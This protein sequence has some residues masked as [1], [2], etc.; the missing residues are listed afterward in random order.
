MQNIAKVVFV[1]AAVLSA[2]SFITVRAGASPQ[3]V[4]DD[5]LDG[6][7]LPPTP[8][9]AGRVAPTEVPMA[10]PLDIEVT[11]DW[12]QIIAE[13]W[14][15]VSTGRMP[16]L[17][18][19]MI[20]GEN[21]K[22]DET[23]PL[24]AEASAEE[25][26]SR[27]AKA[28]IAA[29]NSK[30]QALQKD[31]DALLDKDTRCKDLWKL[32]EKHIDE[33]HNSTVV[34]FGA[35][36]ALYVPARKEHRSMKTSRP[37][38][39][40]RGQ[41]DTS[42]TVRGCISLR[43]AQ[44]RRYATVIYSGHKHYVGSTAEEAD[45][46]AAEA[47]GERVLDGNTYDTEDNTHANTLRRADRIVNIRNK[48]KSRPINHVAGNA[49]V[50][51]STISE[52]VEKTPE[53]YTYAV[54][55]ELRSL[56][57]NMLPHE[58]EQFLGQLLGLSITTFIPVPLP[59]DHY[60]SYWK[61]AE[62]LALAAAHS[63]GLTI[64]AKTIKDNN[65]YNSWL[66]S[67]ST[68]TSKRNE[69]KLDGVLKVQLT[70]W[71]NVKPT[72][73]EKGDKKD[74]KN[75]KSLPKKDDDANKTKKKDSDTK[76]TPPK[77]RRLQSW[78]SNMGN[79]PFHPTPPKKDEKKTGEG[80]ASKSTRKLMPMNLTL[81]DSGVSLQ[82]LN[83]LSITTQD[84]SQI[85]L[86]LL[87]SADASTMVANKPSDILFVRGALE[88]KIGARGR[89]NVRLGIDSATRMDHPR[90]KKAE[91]TSEHVLGE[92]DD[93]D[94]APDDVSEDDDQR[95][96]DDDGDDIV[97]EASE[98]P[99][100]SVAKPALTKAQP[101]PVPLNK[102]LKN[103]P[104]HE[105]LKM[106]S[107]KFSPFKEVTYGLAKTN[108][109]ELY[110]QD[111][112]SKAK[113]VKIDDSSS[114]PEHEK[115][116]APSTETKPSVV[117]AKSKQ[118]KKK[119][120]LSKTKNAEENTGNKHSSK[121]V[122]FVDDG[123]GKQKKQ[124]AKVKPSFRKPKKV[125]V[126]TGRRRRGLRRRLL[127]A[128]DVKRYIRR[129]FL[130][131]RDTQWANDKI[132][133][134]LSMIQHE[135]RGFE[136]WWP[137]FETD[138]ISHRD[139]PDKAKWS[140]LINGE[141][142]GLLSTKLALAFP[143]STVVSVKDDTN[144]MVSHLELLELLGINNNVLCNGR[145]RMATEKK[146]AEGATARYGILGMDAFQIFF[147]HADRLDEFESL[148]GSLLN[149]AS[150]TFM[151]LPDWDALTAAVDAMAN[152][153]INQIEGEKA[154]SEILTA[155][156]LE[157]ASKRGSADPWV[158]LL[159]AAA[160]RADLQGVTMRMLPEMK[161]N[162]SPS[163]SIRSTLLK[164]LRRKIP[165]SSDSIAQMFP[166]KEVP[167]PRIRIVRIDTAPWAKKM[168]AEDT[169]ENGGVS[170]FALRRLGLIPKQTAKI[171]RLFMRL[172]FNKIESEE[173]GS[174]IIAPWNTYYH[175]S[176]GGYRKGFP[177]IVVTFA[178]TGNSYEAYDVPE[179]EEAEEDAEKLV[180]P[181][182][183]TLAKELTEEDVGPKGEFS[184]LELNSGSGL[185]SLAVAEKFPGATVLSVE[186]EAA[187]V[188]AHLQRIKKLGQSRVN[189]AG[190]D[191]VQD[192]RDNVLKDDLAK[193]AANNWVCNT[194][195]GLGL[196]K[197]L[198]ES[199]E[200]IR[201]QVF[202]GDLVLDHMV[203]SGGPEQM[204]EA[205][206]FFMSSGMTTFVTLPSAKSL[207]LGLYMFY[208]GS[209]ERSDTAST[210]FALTSHPRP[211]YMQAEM[212]ILSSMASVPGETK[213]S[214]KLLPGEV[215]MARVD[216]VNM[217]RHVNHHFDYAKDGHQR[218]Y[219]MHVG[220]NASLTAKHGRQKQSSSRAISP[221]P[222]GS[223]MNRG[224]VVDVYITRQHDKWHIPYGTL[225]GVTLI[226]VLRMGL[227]ET[228]REAAYHRFVNLPLY[229]DMAPWNI[230][231]QGARMAYIDYDTKDVT[232]DSV[233]PLTYR[234]LSV[235]FNYKRTVED[236]KR[237]GP[238]SHNDYGFPHINSC[239]GSEK[240]KKDFLRLSGG[241][242]KCKESNAPVPCGD[243]SCQSDYIS[244]L[245]VLSKLEHT[246]RKK[247]HRRSTEAFLNM[248][249][250]KEWTF[251]GSGMSV[252]TG[253]GVE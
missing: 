245:K 95:D 10:D 125:T 146:H 81:S 222:E 13:V 50:T 80:T 14:A 22:D 217:T 174:A 232:Y 166:E 19:P 241:N 24:E 226:T 168:S 230:V 136:R 101:A 8:V 100:I 33:K 18:D 248:W 36:S 53:L 160:Q 211:R 203:D 45:F 121:P 56:T 3:N 25:E 112:S 20:L 114:L 87:R 27:R 57:Q 133:G 62:E 75:D 156:Y 83:L 99:G 110:K 190:S 59:D 223:H 167:R 253:A 252:N 102:G 7:A 89:K 71:V 205:L 148:V 249:R 64:D 104:H 109:K 162:V 26:N 69:Q 118:N 93:N 185:L 143:Q 97:E 238:S 161:P 137:L 237:C 188:A 11:K 144:D 44:A 220:R 78:Y 134:Q 184:F 169:D 55:T 98:P 106:M 4:V 86:T 191:P 15:A 67:Y 91:D 130:Q 105:L 239:V 60:F 152:L 212:Q 210:T 153:K 180:D 157:A 201:W 251:R 31:G 131:K 85:F 28:F 151:E 128:Q 48:L 204:K 39:A 179:N 42:L 243:G 247:P 141:H 30:N 172:D 135:E 61:N 51:P 192:A 32:L 193:V 37:H 227:V 233:V 240:N 208:H 17:P 72:K 126:D 103:V 16:K 213:L 198:Y 111:E 195:V 35:G 58:F 1:V 5:L 242:H 178:K 164:R 214:M 140:I 219:D 2:T 127:S 77:R 197:H 47:A 23:N 182:W 234:V 235:L 68:S 170:V 9:S 163:R 84:S 21:N 120:K 34:E 159:S 194:P 171:F 142:L 147:K 196:L 224:V 186:S 221:L 129:P 70:N 79:N 215:H 66:P 54:L 236:F 228:Q 158:G 231:F 149:T 145:T 175:G 119:K 199:P 96:Y 49:P 189:A 218:K 183:A 150:T 12:E 207:S 200:F 244:C 76:N 139:D 132:K 40:R 38:E 124:K 116:T 177:R 90:F 250:Q 82:T 88:F 209:N 92:G 94:D 122:R 181:R 41:T 173:G 107:K 108:K 202:G 29:A 73:E 216:I 123:V 113:Y 6:D 176:G 43:I 154:V 65:H 225:W 229:E 138:E 63:V 246:K 206:G 74:S 187:N 165:A 52:L 155:K 115:I 46:V 117:V